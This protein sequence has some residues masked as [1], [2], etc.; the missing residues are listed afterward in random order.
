MRKFQ[1]TM[2]L[3]T[4]FISSPS[5]TNQ[6]GRDCALPGYSDTGTKIHV[7]ER[8]IVLPY[9]YMVLV[10]DSPGSVE[11]D[12]SDL[13]NPVPVM[14]RIRVDQVGSEWV[15]I[16]NLSCS[17]VGEISEI[18][19]YSCEMM[20]GNSETLRSDYLVGNRQVM[21]FTEYNVDAI[22]VVIRQ[23]VKTELR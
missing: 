3:I 20:L 2:I 7:F 17:L 1:C 15:N 16:E 22:N 6:S 8:T 12:Y 21:R 23:L 10:S 11:L 9:Q 4:F 18:R 5:Y 14:S 13:T 19:H